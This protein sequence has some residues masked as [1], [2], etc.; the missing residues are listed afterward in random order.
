MPMSTDS[1][2]TQRLANTERAIRAEYESFK[3]AAL[4]REMELREEIERLRGTVR[5]LSPASVHLIVIFMNIVVLISM[6][7]QY[8]VTIKQEHCRIS[9][10]TQTARSRWI[11]LQLP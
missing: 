7:D 1:G 2:N 3:K 10:A 6:Y 8:S 9:P 5:D 4:S 11:W